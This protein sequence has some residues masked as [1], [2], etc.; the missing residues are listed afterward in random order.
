MKGHILTFEHNLQL[1]P[2]DVKDA[3]TRAGLGDDVALQPTPAGVL[4]EVIAGL[5]RRIHVLQEPR[6]FGGKTG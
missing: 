1:V 3:V 2:E 6:R 4:V 5:H